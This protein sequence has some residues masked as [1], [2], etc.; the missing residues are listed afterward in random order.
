MVMNTQNEHMAVQF[1]RAFLGK[2]QIL[3]A[4]EKSDASGLYG[5]RMRQRQALVEHLSAWLWRQ[6]SVQAIVKR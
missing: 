2:G 1:G 3:W 5:F 6:C 4:K